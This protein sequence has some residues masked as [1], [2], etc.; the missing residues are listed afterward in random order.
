[1][2]ELMPQVGFGTSANV[3]P[4]AEYENRPVR[5]SPTCDPRICAMRC[6]ILSVCG[7]PNLLAA[8]SSPG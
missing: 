8:L 1:M 2:A 5:V 7:K 3:R 6:Q 4:T